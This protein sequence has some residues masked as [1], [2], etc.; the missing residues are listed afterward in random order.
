[1]RGAVEAV[2]ASLPV[3]SWYKETMPTIYNERGWIRVVEHATGLVHVAKRTNGDF[4]PHPFPLCV[5]LPGPSPDY[6]SL[7]R[8]FVH[9]GQMITCLTCLGSKFFL[10]VEEFI[11]G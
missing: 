7:S 8:R 11:D 9:T 2:G 10:H 4:G 5:V 3:V 1:M 6:A